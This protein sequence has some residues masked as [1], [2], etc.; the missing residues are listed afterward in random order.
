[1]G[2]NFVVSNV[3]EE[4]EEEEGSNNCEWN[5]RGNENTDET[6]YEGRAFLKKIKNTLYA[7]VQGKL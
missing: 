6:V 3:E 5:S 1:M 4:E 7:A 2:F